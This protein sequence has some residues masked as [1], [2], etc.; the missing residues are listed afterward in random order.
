MVQKIKFKF[1]GSHA[2]FYAV[3]SYT[4][5]LVEQNLDLFKKF[6]TTEQDLLDAKQCLLKY[7]QAI[8]DQAMLVNQLNI[9]VH[10]RQLVENLKN[11][12]R[13]VTSFLK[14]NLTLLPQ[15]DFY[16]LNI[17]KLA[18]LSS[19]QVS[20]DTKKLL[21]SIENYNN[22]IN[23]YELIESNIETINNLFQQIRDIDNKHTHAQNNRK[24]QTNRRNTL[25][26]QL[27]DHVIRFSTI[28]KALFENV[29]KAMAQRFNMY[30]HTPKN[31][32]PQT[33]NEEVPQS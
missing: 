33:V 18:K 25:A 7:D 2:D 14:V 16:V 26:T 21:Q 20:N 6:G 24:I 23:N 29:D 8:P 3:S 5:T 19:K 17:K 4:L 31:A 28:G 11:E 30:K 32:E 12:L 10:K 27:Y 22:S 1:R 13:Y 15:Q 9:S